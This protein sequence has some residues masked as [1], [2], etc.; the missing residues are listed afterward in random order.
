MDFF[1]KVGSAD[2]TL[3]VYDGFY[4]A[5]LNAPGSDGVLAEIDAW[6]SA[7]T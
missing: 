5:L 7:R 6:L 1:E 4:H 3:N 2:K